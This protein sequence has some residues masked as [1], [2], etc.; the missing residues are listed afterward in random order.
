MQPNRFAI[1]VEAGVRGLAALGSLCAF[2]IFVCVA[3]DIIG[4]EVFRAS[5][6]YA[7]DL[8]EL[9]MVP[10]VF[11]VLPYVAQVG[12]NVRVDIVTN[13][14]GPRLRFACNLLGHVLFLP[15]AGLIGWGGWLAAH[16]AYRFASTTESGLMIWPALAAIPAGSAVLSVQVLVLIGRDLFQPATAGRPGWSVA[17]DM[18]VELALIL[19]AA[20]L[21]SLIGLPI[22]AALGT[23]GFLGVAVIFGWKVAIGA[24]SLNVSTSMRHFNLVSVPMFILMAEILIFSDLSRRLF[25]NASKLLGGLPGKSPAR[26]PVRD[27]P[28]LHADRVERRKLR[29]DRRRRHPRDDQARL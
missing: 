7:I 15:F 11:L 12:A 29:G 20:L 18:F 17:M 19:G 2:A 24:L 27:D 9:L 4:R 28:V 16:D 1:T 25:D 5:T 23:V 10:L 6:D 8:S 13:N 22:A 26:H 3:A 14:L 21:L